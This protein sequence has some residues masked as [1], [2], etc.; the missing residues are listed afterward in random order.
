MN[1]LYKQSMIK[2]GSVDSRSAFSAL[3]CGCIA[4]VGAT[5]PASAAPSD[6][7]P[8]AAQAQPAPPP[9]ATTPSA[10]SSPSAATPAPSTYKL[11]PE[12][13][14]TIR[15]ARHPEMDTE[16]LVLEDGT[17]SLPRVGRRTVTGM[18][19]LQ[20]QEMVR[21]E[22]LKVLRNPQVSVAIRTP[23]VEL[24]HVTGAVN[25][26]GPVP[27]KEGW[28]VTEALGKAGGLKLRPDWATLTLTRRQGGSQPISIDAILKSADSPENV[29]VQPGDVLV[30]NEIPPQMVFIGGAVA[31][32]AM[33]DLREVDPK[34]GAIGVLEAIALA[35]GALAGGSTTNN[36]VPQ[37]ALSKAYIDRADR[38]SSGAGQTVASGQRRR[39]FVNI[40]LL[41][42]ASTITPVS[43]TAVSQAAPTEVLLYP[44][45]T[46]TIPES[47]ARIVVTGNVRQQGAFLISEDRPI[48][49][50]EALGMAGGPA[51]R[52]KMSEVGILRSP[53]P[54]NP[55]VGTP[56]LIRADLKKLMSAKGG[57]D[58]RQNPVLKPGDI[59]HVPETSKPDWFGKILP[60][61]GSIGNI[62]YFGG[63]T[64]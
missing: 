50:Y 39:E 40:A 9:P 37:A 54:N 35:G 11:G 20:V 18:T 33:Y 19:V 45:D 8:V 58:P 21:K 15:V 38:T 1:K 4:L 46:L 3:V 6:P 60:A 17:V 41:Q 55:G 16:A 47:T 59:I 23:R 61:L 13:V 53:D 28:R 22:L 24:V 44:G 52:A 64:N 25:M 14:I 7:A 51:P 49:L 36:V 29:P 48:T 62:L 12:D 26:P 30:V 56:T 10:M 27:Y 31:K 2:N 34:R 32:P 42:K 57:A 5:G 63:L 43:T